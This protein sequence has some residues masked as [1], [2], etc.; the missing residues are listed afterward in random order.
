MYIEGFDAELDLKEKH[1]MPRDQACTAYDIKAFLHLID[2]TV[3]VGSLNVINND[4]RAF[5]LVHVWLNT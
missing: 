3:F 5:T 1:Q 4:N 2:I